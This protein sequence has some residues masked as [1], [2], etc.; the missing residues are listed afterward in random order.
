M[1]NKICVLTYFIVCII[2]QHG[3]CQSA[4]VGDGFV[5]TKG[6]HFILNGKPHYVNGF[7]AYWLMI[8][9]SNPSTRSNVTSAFE[10]ASKHGLNLGRTIAFNDGDIDP[11]QI[12]PGSYNETVF[13]GLDFVISEAGKFGVKLML[14]FVNNW[15]DLGGKMKYV[16]WAR[17]RGQNITNE[18]D[19]FT[20]PLVKEFYKNH[21]MAVVTRNNTINGVLYKDDQTIFSWELM[22]EPRFPNDSSGN[23][24]QNWV[25]EMAA[26]VKSIDSNH[27]LHIGNEGFYGS[28]KQ[29]L[30]PLSINFGTDF[31]ENN[32]IP[33]IDF[34]TFHL[35]DD[36]WL[37]NKTE[38]EKS[39][40]VDKWIEAHLKD[41]DTVLGKPIILA[42][43]GKSSRE[44]PEYTI[45]KRDSYF[46][47]IYNA[48]YT[49]AA[50]GGSCA[51]AMFWQLL[52]QGMDSFGDGYEVI[53]E[54]SLSTAEIIK[55][56]STIMSN[57]TF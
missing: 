27:L 14:S 41:A 51:G 36:R 17:E 39:E 46:Q 57:I 37:E 10:Q 43:F 2:V 35:Y 18:D 20:D 8:L 31:I 25:T 55:Q 42:E 6:N 24:I 19:F 49:S 22:N 56:Q 30:N 9:A 16:Q 7:N 5:Q 53:L 13:E 1:R 29:Q 50:S 28:E 45:A 12:S 23:S 32:Q 38:E 21:V 11:L 3:N 26:Y 4:N 47:K 54:D 48:I 33:D 52:S 40:F 15:K 44:S 34:A